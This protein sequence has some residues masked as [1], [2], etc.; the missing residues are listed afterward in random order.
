MHNRVPVLTSLFQKWTIKKDTY[1][2]P[3]AESNL[4]ESSTDGI[5]EGL[6]ET[7]EIEVGAA[8]FVVMLMSKQEN[9]LELTSNTCFFEYFTLC[10][11]GDLLTLNKKKIN[12]QCGNWTSVFCVVTCDVTCDNMQRH[13]LGFLRTFTLFTSK[14]RN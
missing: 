13:M 2:H 1:I 9:R 12:V 10:R 11:L 5:G 14:G 3:G 8:I 4:V 6:A 7:D